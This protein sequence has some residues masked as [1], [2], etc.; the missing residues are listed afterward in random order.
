MCHAAI[1]TADQLLIQCLSHHIFGII[2]ANFWELEMGLVPLV[3]CG[4]T[5]EKALKNPFLF[6]GICL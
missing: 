3:I 1:E 4:G 6:F 5:G 2:L